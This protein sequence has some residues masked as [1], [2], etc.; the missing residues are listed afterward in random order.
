MLDLGL[1]SIQVYLGGLATGVLARL[2][3]WLALTLL[4]VSP[5]VLAKLDVSKL[6]R[7]VLWI[8]F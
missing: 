8:K 6:F 4:L 5:L 7:S 2:R 3:G 1:A